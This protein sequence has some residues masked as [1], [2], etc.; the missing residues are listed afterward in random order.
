MVENGVKGSI[1][2][3]T[4]VRSFAPHSGDG[5]YGGLKA[6][7]NRTIQSFAIELGPYGIRVNGFAPGVTNVRAAS[8]E[9]E[10]DSPMYRY[11][12]RFIPLRRNGYAE[13]MGK[14]VAFLVSDNASY[15]TGQVIRVD[16][17]LSIV[18]GPENM[19]DL[20]NAFDVAEIADAQG[21]D[22]AEYRA[23]NT[24]YSKGVRERKD[25]EVREAVE[26]LGLE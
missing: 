25:R 1:I 12:H 26:R 8:P 14:V 24:A 9:D 3:N 20:Y 23:R 18:G 5:V 4:S 17:G 10:K 21:Y 7:L 15:I 16:G 19:P 6:G 11:S 2:F 22:V 13:D